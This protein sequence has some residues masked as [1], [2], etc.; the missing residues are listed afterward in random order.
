MR[1]IHF[2]N[3]IRAIEDITIGHRFRRD[4]GDLSGLIASIRDI[5]LLN[6]PVIASDGVLLCGARRLAAVRQLGWR[7]LEVRVQTDVSAGLSAVL[8]EQHENELRLALAPTEEASLF[9]ELREILGADARHRQEATRFGAA[10]ALGAGAGGEDSSP[11]HEAT[12]KTREHAALAITGKTSFQRLEQINKI[13][14]VVEDPHLPLAVRK[15]AETTLDEIDAG[16]PVDPNYRKVTTAVQLAKATPPPVNEAAK[17]SAEEI[18][19]LSREALEVDRARRAE[20]V[21][22][23]AAQRLTTRP[24]RR[25]VKALFYSWQELDG[26]TQHYDVEQVARDL[27]DHEWEIV[28]RVL[29]ESVA[30]LDAVAEARATLAAHNSPAMAEAG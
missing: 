13:Q 4:L 2:V 15:M 11:P 23:L 24:V 6:P 29:A 8:A 9:A 19:K 12:G 20:H 3:E 26:W 7:Q 18:A 10:A 28:R 30:F 14:Q 1:E 27:A 16:A 25:S 17:A 22:A 5:G 21:R